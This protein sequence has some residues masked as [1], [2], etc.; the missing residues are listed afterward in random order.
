MKYTRQL[1]DKELA[2][3]P[4]SEIDYSD[5]PELG[6]EFWKNAKVFQPSSRKKM[7]SLRL[8]ED[9]IKWFKHKAK[10]A[11]SKG[12]QTEINAILRSFMSAHS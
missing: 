1:T 8:D 2:A 12:Y 3:M 6:E 10:I 7:V 4:D 9:I 5:I 11:K